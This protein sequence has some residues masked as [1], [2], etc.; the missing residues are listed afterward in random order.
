M[1]E[2]ESI[3]DQLITAISENQETLDSDQEITLEDL[4]EFMGE[5]NY[6]LLQILLRIKEQDDLKKSRKE[7]LQGKSDHLYS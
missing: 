3:I 5:I 2:E 6:S 7:N 4:R 1:S